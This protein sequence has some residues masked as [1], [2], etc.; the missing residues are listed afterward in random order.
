[1]DGAVGPNR[2]RTPASYDQRGGGWRKAFVPL[3]FGEDFFAGN[4]GKHRIKK[5]T[6]RRGGGCERGGSG[7][8]NEGKK[9][10]MVRK[11]GE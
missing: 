5:R 11:M 8:W 6:T 2:K 9:W 1:V 7:L 3:Y 10:D 4:S